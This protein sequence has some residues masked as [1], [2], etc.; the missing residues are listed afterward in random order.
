MERIK[1]KDLMQALLSAIIV[2]WS[3]GILTFYAINQLSVDGIAGVAIAGLIGVASLFGIN[4]V[5]Q[6]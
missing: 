4:I 5:R 3:L 1:L 2:I 6:K